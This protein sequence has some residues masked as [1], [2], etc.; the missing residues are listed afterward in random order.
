MTLFLVS[1][2]GV[3]L[4]A[5]GRGRGDQVRL[6]GGFL[7]PRLVGC[8]RHSTA[9]REWLQFLARATSVSDHEIK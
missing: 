3:R 9:E 4:A 1:D 8:N 6:H 2:L 7:P 5:R